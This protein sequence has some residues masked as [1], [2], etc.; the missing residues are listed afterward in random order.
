MSAAA[1]RRP[2]RV[3]PLVT[4][5]AAILQVAAVVTLLLALLIAF[6]TT[7]ISIDERSREHATMIAFG[8]PIRTVLGITT[9]ETVLVGT[10]GTIGGIL[11]GYAVLRWM[12]ETTIPSVLPDIGVTAS[13]S[14]TTLAEALTL[15]ILTVAAA[16][17]FTVRRLRHMDI[18]STLRV[19]E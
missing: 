19:V 5:V 15:G 17:L 9:V 18:P 8:L 1:T 3:G 4:K 2:L 6:N 11:G 10:L 7:S 14:T 13:L 12:T 16:P